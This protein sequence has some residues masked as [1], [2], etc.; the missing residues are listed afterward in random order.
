MIQPDT[1]VKILLRNNTIAEGIVQD[2]SNIVKLKSVDDQSYMIILHPE[3][4]IILIKVFLKNSSEE[5]NKTI[6]IEYS[7]EVKT[8]LEQNFQQTIEQPS[9]DPSRNKSL[10][11]LK[12]LLGQQER[13][14][15]ANKLKQHHIGESKKV[16]YGYPR[17]YSKPS[18]K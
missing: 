8:E 13:Q 9:D 18:S 17:F 11:E 4:D 15:V 1:H 10:A 2:W 16:E 14:I 12:I 7:E 3:E 6:P 5:K